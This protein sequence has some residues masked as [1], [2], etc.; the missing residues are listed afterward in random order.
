MLGAWLMLQQEKPDDYIL[1]SGIGH[2]VA[3]FAEQ[4]FAYAGLSLEDYVSFDSSLRRPPEPTPRV[5][6]ST[7]ARERLGWRPTL[8]FDALIKRMVDADVRA[9]EADRMANG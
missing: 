7:R 6:D 8:S 5:G 2:T 1:A 3:E 9:L 4:A